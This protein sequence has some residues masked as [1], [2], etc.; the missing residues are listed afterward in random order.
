VRALD[1]EADTGGRI[2]RKST[3]YRARAHLRS[4][5]GSNSWASEWND[6][7]AHV[8]AA[9]ELLCSDQPHAYKVGMDECGLC[10]G[11]FYDEIHKADK[12]LATDYIGSITP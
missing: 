4:A 12:D 7:M 5:L 1:L 3:V 6:V 2:M 10:G 11:D 8:R 9:H